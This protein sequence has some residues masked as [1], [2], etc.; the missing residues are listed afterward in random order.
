[1]I[2]AASCWF[3]AAGADGAAGEGATFAAGRRYM[4][5]IVGRSAAPNGVDKKSVGRSMLARRLDMALI[6]ALKIAT[7]P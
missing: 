2:D 1:M 4:A 6:H 7:H 5:S 3:V